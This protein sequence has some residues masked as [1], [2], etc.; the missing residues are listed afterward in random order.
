MYKSIYTVQQI[1]S[2]THQKNECFFFYNKDEPESH[3]ANRMA[4]NDC[5]T[6]LGFCLMPRESFPNN[7]SNKIYKAVEVDHIA[8]IG[9]LILLP[10]QCF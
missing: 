6:P 4:S 9:L 1:N 3:I 7:G 8:G 2:N 10:S 5:K